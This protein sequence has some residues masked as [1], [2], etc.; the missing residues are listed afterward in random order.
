MNVIS[1]NLTAT[2]EDFRRFPE[3]VQTLPKMSEDVLTKWFPEPQIQMQNETRKFYRAV[4]KLGY[5]VNIK[6]LFGGN[7][8]EF[9]LLIMC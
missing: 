6:R 7:L 1:E 9:L 3:D 5:K 4:I 8:I 2:S